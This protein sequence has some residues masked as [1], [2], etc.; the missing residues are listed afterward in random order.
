VSTPGHTIGHVSF[1][2]PNRDVL[3]AGDAVVTFNPYTGTHG[4]QIVARSAN[5]DSPRA[6]ASLDAIAATGAGTVL[7]GHG[8]A[9]RDG[10]EAIA[11][12]ARR[13]GIS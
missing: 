11:E 9:W 4:P 12:Q 13:A 6:L 5:A 7:T 3:V 1:H 10:A 8:P 2:P